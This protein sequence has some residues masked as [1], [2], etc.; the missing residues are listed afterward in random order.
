[1]S[2]EQSFVTSTRPGAVRA[3]SSRS[4]APL[5]IS[6]SLSL[7]YRRE[8]KAKASDKP[9][10]PKPHESGCWPVCAG[11]SSN[12]RGL[13]SLKREFDVNFGILLLSTS[14]QRPGRE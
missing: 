3:F 10:Q 13:H 8:R 4:R 12:Q 11:G 14:P 1:M 7:V 9:P 5:W 6:P 2:V